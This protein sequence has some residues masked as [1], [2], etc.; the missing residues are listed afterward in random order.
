MES[1]PGPGIVL[2]AVTQAGPMLPVTPEDAHAYGSFVKTGQVLL[3]VVTLT[4]LP[5]NSTVLTE[6][7][8]CAN[9]V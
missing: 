4:F 9:L 3:R 5:V 6:A 1:S 7:S 8:F 2:V